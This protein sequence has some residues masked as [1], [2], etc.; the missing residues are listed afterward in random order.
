MLFRSVL[1]RIAEEVGNHT[2]NI[3][4]PIISLRREDAI[5]TG[6]DS[7]EVWHNM[8]SYFAPEIAE[9]MKIPIE[10]FR[11]YAAFHN[12]S[13]HPHVHMVCYSTNPREGY[14]TKKGIERMKSGLVKSIFKNEM[15]LIYEEQTRR[16]DLLKS[17]SREAMLKLIQEI[18]VGTVNNPRIEELFLHLSK[19]LKSS[20]GKKVCGYLTPWLK[21]IV[22]ELIDEISKEQVVSKAYE[23]W[24]EMREEVINSYMEIGRAHV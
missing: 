4:I 13:H 18:K 11:W 19:E 8:L 7:A 1:S 22:D 24:Y 9:S 2:G 16:R 20:T 3:W 5:R 15:Q 21:A 17:E 12:E 23:L 6:F 10:N 14:L